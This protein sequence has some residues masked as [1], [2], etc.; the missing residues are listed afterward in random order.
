MMRSVR[1]VGQKVGEESTANLP[2][3][4]FASLSWWATSGVCCLYMRRRAYMRVYE[5]VCPGRFVS[6]QYDLERW[7][8]LNNTVLVSM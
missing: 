3:V 4:V 7:K 6:R 8:T 1:V 2:M 5:L